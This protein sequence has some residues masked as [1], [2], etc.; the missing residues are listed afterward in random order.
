MVEACVV[1]RFDEAPRSRA[2]TTLFLLR[3][4]AALLEAVGGLR[5]RSGCVGLL[6]GAVR[7]GPTS[8]LFR[9]F[10]SKVWGRRADQHDARAYAVRPLRVNAWD[11]VGPH[12]EDYIKAKREPHEAICATLP[13]GMSLEIMLLSDPTAGEAAAAHRATQMR[14]RKALLPRKT[15]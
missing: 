10:P 5:W 11:G 12:I 9:G 4:A 8:P 13:P 1:R 3:S 6:S 14:S 2:S 7:L 15:K